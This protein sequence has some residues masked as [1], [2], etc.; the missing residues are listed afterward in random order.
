MFKSRIQYVIKACPSDNPQA[1]ETLLNDMAQKGW[2]L[3]SM[4]EVENENGFDFHC[5]FMSEQSQKD[6]ES[7]D[8]SLVN[9]KTFKSQMEKMLTANFTP[10]ESCRE[11]QGKIREQ[12]NKISKIKTQLENEAPAS[13]SR[14][15][16]NDEMSKSLKS[17][18]S[19]K[20]QLVREIS[21]D[22]MFSQIGEEK[23]E[24]HLSEEILEFVNPDSDADLLTQTVKVREK[25]TQELGYI[26]PK[27]LFKDDD[28]LAPYEFSIR[29]HGLDVI[30]DYIYPNRV[31]FFESD[32]KG[33][34]IPKDAPRSI[35]AITREAIVWL[36]KKSVK[37]FWE[38]GY[39]PQD[40]LA[41]V[42]EFVAI[43]YVEELLD[44]ADVNRYIEIIAEKNSFLVDNIIPDFLS[45]AELK[46]LLCNLIRERVSI[47]DIFYIF[48]KLNDFSDDL[49]KEGLLDKLRLSLSPHICE[50]LKTSENVI[51]VLDI[52]EKTVDNFFTKMK[53][54]EQIIRVDGEK[55]EKF[56][57]QIVKKASASGLEPI[58][59]CAPYEVRHI[60][61]TVF[62]QVLNDF[63]VISR[64]EVGS[65][66]IL[67]LVDEI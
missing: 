4:H 47:K 13:G 51:Y 34:K 35:D 27:I 3:Y 6:E 44:Y 55:L 17:L 7:Y 66:A 32:I 48:E 10:Y 5:I 54:D 50:R 38:N 11:I 52:T 67:E 12:K 42:L 25:L 53:G 24:I 62:S 30:K 15:K 39:T 16:L 63:Y 37:N 14:K 46:Y 22:L 21:P 45:I 8:E 41:R 33:A 60:L 31:M 49:D 36:E 61:F 57:E 26:L 23:L 43:K 59:L 28:I 2:D 58:V 19:L 1:L 29:I 9:I 18:D 40:Y 65:N 56:A 20:Q 64:E